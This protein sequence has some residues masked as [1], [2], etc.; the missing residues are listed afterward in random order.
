MLLNLWTYSSAPRRRIVRLR[1]P[2]GFGLINVYALSDTTSTIEVGIVSVA[3][4]A[5]NVNEEQYFWYQFWIGRIIQVKLGD[6]KAQFF[7]D[8]DTWVVTRGCIQHNDAYITPYT[9]FTLHHDVVILH[10]D[11]QN[12]TEC[13]GDLKRFVAL[14]MAMNDSVL[15]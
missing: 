5:F 12:K 13:A 14:S 15:Y 2:I 3:G 6:D 9:N 4:T 10:V 7:G 1:I 8:D 11:T